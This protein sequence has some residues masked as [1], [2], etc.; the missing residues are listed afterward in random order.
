MISKDLDIILQAVINQAADERH[1]YITV[2]HLLY[3]LLH[4]KEGADILRACGANLFELEK[5]LDDHLAANVP[6]KNSDKTPEPVPT[7]GFQR[8]IQRMMI[9]VQASEKEARAGDLLVAIFSEPDRM[10]FSSSET[11]CQPARCAQLRF[12]RDT[13]GRRKRRWLHRC[14]AR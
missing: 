2:E 10:R 14:R 8:V 3:A 7:L 12:T 5:D 13:Q 9:H 4:D 11:E 1:E 6:Q